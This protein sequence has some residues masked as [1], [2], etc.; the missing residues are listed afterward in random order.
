MVLVKNLLLLVSQSGSLGFL[1][2]IVDVYQQQDLNL[3]KADSS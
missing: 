1:S 2:Q 3:R